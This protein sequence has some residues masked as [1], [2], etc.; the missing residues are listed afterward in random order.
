MS[1]PDKKRQTD[2]GDEA[3]ERPAEKALEYGDKAVG[4]GVL[5]AQVPQKKKG[6]PKSR[7]KK[8]SLH[9][10][11]TSDVFMH[12]YF[13]KLA[14]NYTDEQFFDYIVGQ[15]SDVTDPNRFQLAGIQIVLVNDP[16]T[17]VSDFKNS[18][19]TAGAVV[20][21]FGHTVL[22]KNKKK[23]LGLT[24][25]VS[26]KPAITSADLV[27]LLNKSNAKI[28]L[29]AGCATDG[30]VRG[31]KGDIVVVVTRSGKDRLTNTLQWAPAIKAFLD[32]L[33]DNF[34]TAGDALA[35]ANKV[36]AKVSSTDKFDIINGDPTLKLF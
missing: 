5:V 7:K 22:G 33:I 36:F 12:V 19:S 32:E 30:C 2:Y 6:T 18:L 23:T 31:V 25:D 14:T 20:V 10:V 13:K 15:S 28:V 27:K 9:G 11:I 8:S 17:L 35:A 29:L 3:V 16:K 4:Q 26:K 34:G 24:P 21:Y 1:P